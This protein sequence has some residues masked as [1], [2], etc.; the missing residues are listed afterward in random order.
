VSV[1]AVRP[2]YEVG[3]PVAARVSVAEGDGSRVRQCWVEL[4]A[5]IWD[6]RTRKERFYFVGWPYGTSTT[7]EPVTRTEVLSRAEAGDLAGTVLPITGIT[8]ELTLPGAPS[9]PSGST[10]RMFLHYLLEAQVE[11][12]NG[13]K[14]RAF[15]RVAVVSRRSTY[16]DVEGAEYLRHVRACDLELDVPVPHARLGETIEGVLRVRAHEPVY[17]RL[18]LGYLYGI[19]LGRGL[20]GWEE[21]AAPRVPTMLGSLQ[22]FTATKTRKRRSAVIHSD[23]AT[24]RGATLAR[25]V[26]LSEPAE[27]AFRQGVRADICPTLITDD[28]SVRYYVCGEIRYAHRRGGHDILA[29]EVNIHSG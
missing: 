27:F 1:S 2:E 7:N 10:K 6:G 29:R 13:R 9:A 15:A 3:E 26:M 14:A 17:A 23:A 12:D 4:R 25:N 28:C 19:W 5:E 20:P 16:Q 8:R 21:R 11:L 22:Y 18:V 24:I